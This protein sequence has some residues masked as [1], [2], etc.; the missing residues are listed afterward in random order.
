VIPPANPQAAYLAQREEIDAA[1]HRVLDSGWY[2]LGREVEAFEREFADWLGAAH[3]IGVANGTDAVELALRAVGVGPGDEVIAPAHTATATIAAIEHAGA[4]PVL[5]DIESVTFGLDPEKLCATIRA[6]AAAGR[7]KAIVVVHLYGHPARIDEI[8]AIAHETGLR[9]V[10]DCAQ[11]H[12][13]RWRGRM[14]GTMGDVAAFSFYPTKNLGALG[15]GGAVAT[16]YFDV[17]ARVRQL[18]EYGWRERYR[19]EVP[20]INSRLDELQAAIL[21]VKL[22]RLDEDNQRRRA[23]A[24]RYD[25][26]MRGVGLVAPVV[27]DG[28]VH[29]YHQYAVMHPRREQWQAELRARGTGSAVLYPL[30]LHQQ[31]AYVGRIPVGVGG[32]TVSE[33]VCRTVACLPVY[34]HLTDAE[35]YRIV[36]AISLPR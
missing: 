32:L 6:R 31:P 9:L 3:A 26:A 35:V 18:R 22:G 5:V 24:A 21:R 11:A 16:T 27:R 10:E 29:A 2:I 36:G 28:A 7:L 14:A 25:E 4:V 23:I 34:P 30:A 33:L 12:G 15:D 19:S 8:A 1:I 17:A 13:A 20:G